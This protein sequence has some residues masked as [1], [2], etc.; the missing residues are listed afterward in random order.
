MTPSQARSPASGASTFAAAVR[1][2]AAVNAATAGATPAATALPGLT[3]ASALRVEP[4]EPAR[5]ALQGARVPG[6]ISTF[7]VSGPIAA[8][9][10]AM[11]APMNISAAGAEGGGTRRPSQFT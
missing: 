4:A 7:L 10:V 9:S 11:T 8:P 5:G 1:P 2:A 3:R 6:Y